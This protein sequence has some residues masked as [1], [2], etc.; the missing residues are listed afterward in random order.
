LESA[1]TA[2]SPAQLFVHGPSAVAAH[3]TLATEPGCKFVQTNSPLRP[4]DAITG[5]CP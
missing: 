4:K 5:A 3:S 1:A 2:S